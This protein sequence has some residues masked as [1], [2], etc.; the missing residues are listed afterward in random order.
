MTHF[1]KR[2]TL[3]LMSL[4]LL[5]ILLVTGCSKSEPPTDPGYYTGP[6]EGKNKLS[7]GPGGAAGAAA[8]AAKT[9]KGAPQ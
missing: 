4:A 5:G 9:G 1:T 6:M 8:P 7:G 3:A 2:G